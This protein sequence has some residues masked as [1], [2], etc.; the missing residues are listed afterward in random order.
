MSRVDSSGKMTKTHS[1]DKPWDT[2]DIDHWKIE[3]F[4]QGEMRGSLLEESYLF[5]PLSA[6]PGTLL[7][8]DMAKSS[9]P[10]LPSMASL[11]S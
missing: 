1:K 8:T 4:L 11:A 2:E 7:E 5:H 9:R 3:P 6:I 10:Y